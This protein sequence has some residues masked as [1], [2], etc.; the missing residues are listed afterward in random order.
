MRTQPHAV[1]HLDATRSAA[2]LEHGNV[3]AVIQMVAAHEIRVGRH[4]DALPH[5][6]ARCGKDLAVEPDVRVIA[7]DDVAVLAAEDGVTPDEDPV[8]DRNAPVVGALGVEAALVVDDHV[9]ADLNLVGMP[10]GDVLAEHHVAPHPAEDQRIELRPQQQAQRP[11][12]RAGQ[13][14]DELE[15]DE[16]PPAGLANHQ[17]AI[18]VGTRPALVEQLALNDR[19]ARVVGAGRACRHQCPSAPTGAAAS[20]TSRMT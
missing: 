18:F 3:D 7:N 11:G 2:L 20:R 14:H 4:Q 12:H 5:R 9:V 13:Q 10:E 16:R 8:A 1:A 17:L 15:S 6:H 19:D